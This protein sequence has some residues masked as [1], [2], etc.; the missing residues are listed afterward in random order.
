MPLMQAERLHANHHGLHDVEE[1]IPHR[2]FHE[3]ANR[4]QDGLWAAEWN[5]PL[6]DPIQKVMKTTAII[7]LST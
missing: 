7:H 1:L 2:I 4:R 5:M 3:D 6:A